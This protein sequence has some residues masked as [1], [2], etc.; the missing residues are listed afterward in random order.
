MS[1]TDDQIAALKDLREYILQKRRAIVIAQGD[2]D[3]RIKRIIECQ[4]ALRAI[5]EA[6]LEEEGEPKPRIPQIIPL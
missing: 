6:I 1:E 3:G 5:D 2:K 4:E